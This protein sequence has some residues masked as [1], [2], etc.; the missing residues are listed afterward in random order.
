VVDRSAFHGISASGITFLP[1]NNFIFNADGI[2]RVSVCFGL[3]NA[4]SF[5]GAHQFLT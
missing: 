5:F 2:K 1:G 4:P 3:E